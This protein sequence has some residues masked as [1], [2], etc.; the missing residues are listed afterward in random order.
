MIFLIFLT[1]TIIL[2]VCYA[3]HRDFCAPAVL[4]TIGFWISSLWA[5]VYQDNWGGFE[6]SKL[7]TLI[8]F[9]VASFCL[10]CFVVQKID[11]ISTHKVKTQHLTPIVFPSRKAIFYLFFELLMIIVI[12]YVI[13][14]NVGAGNIFTMIGRY[15]NAN[16]Y[17]QIVYDPIYLSIM[18]YF[19]VGGVFLFEYMILNNIV[20]KKRNYLYSYFIVGLG[21]IISLLQGTRNALFMFI[22]SGAVLYFILKS[23]NTGWKANITIKTF[24]KGLFTAAICI[25]IFKLSLIATGR[26]SEEYTYVQLLSSY[27]GAPLKNMELFISEWHAKS[28]TFLGATFLQTY[29]KIYSLTVNEIFDFPN[30]YTYRWY[31]SMGLGNVYTTLMP[32]YYDFGIVGA[33][34]TMAILGVISQKQFDSIKQTEYSGAIDNRVLIYSYCAYSISFSFF[35]NKYFEMVIST[36]FIYWLVGVL[37]LKIFIFGFSVNQSKFIVKLR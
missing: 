29:R 34:V 26:N 31:G 15:Y 16:K 21:M 10:A 12:I 27:I 4:L 13:G 11:G 1:M 2:I 5:W 37:F 18:Q 28:Q 19:N 3:F 32:F 20:C 17:G 24:I 25:G 22:I 14:R 7:F 23:L 30:L 9:G 6:N 35:S 33:C 36:S 8:V